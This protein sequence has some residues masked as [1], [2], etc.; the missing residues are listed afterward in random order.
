VSAGLWELFAG[1]VSGCCFA[2]VLLLMRIENKLDRLMAQFSLAL[3][4][5]S[6]KR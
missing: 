4:Y 5:M 2:A 6:E 1:I 3:K